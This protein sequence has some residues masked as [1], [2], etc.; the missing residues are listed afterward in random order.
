MTEKP[1]RRKSSIS[2]RLTVSI[3]GLGLFAVF[4]STA[5]RGYFHHRGNTQ[6]L[7]KHVA[8]VVDI[9]T[10]TLQEDAKQG[11]SDLEGT[12]RHLIQQPKIIYAQL[13]NLSTTSD[14]NITVEREHDKSSFMPVSTHQYFKIPT[15]VG[16]LTLHIYAEESSLDTGL[17]RVLIE[18]LF[19]EGGLVTCLVFF[20]I[21]TLK[22]RL[23]NHVSQITNF[24]RNLS[25]E[26]LG[27]SLEIIRHHDNAKNYD[28][29]DELVDAL[30]HM[31]GKFIDDLDQRRSMELALIREKEEKM[32][33]ERMIK[34]AEAA[35]L[36]KSKF[37]ATMSHEIRTPMNGVVG[38]VEMLRD[39]PLNDNQ[40]HYL[41]VIRRSSDSLMS[42]INDILDYSKIEAGRM[43]LEKV[44]FSLEELINDALQLFGGSNKKQNIQ[45]IS[46]ITPTT[47]IKL[48]GDPTR[49]RQVLVNLIGNAF[50]FTSEGYIFVEAHSLSTDYSEEPVIRFSIEDS[51]IGIKSEIKDSLFDAFRQADST[52]TRKY[53]GTGL[54]LAICKQLAEL[55]GGEIG[56]ES[57]ENKGSTF[58]FTAHLALPPEVDKRD[59]PSTSLSL[60]N[61]KLLA[62]HDSSILEKALR[63]HYVCW[64]LKCRTV[65]FA[66]DGL[67]LLK[68]SNKN[69]DRYDFILINR[70]LPDIDGIDLAIK[71]RKIRGY[72]NTP[73][74]MLT[75]SRPTSLT[76]E[77]L[78]A[79]TTI[80]PRPLSIMQI[81]NT[82]VAQ[83]S[84]ISLNT[85]EPT[86]P[87]KPQVKADLNVLVAEDNAVNRM[88]IEGLLNKFEIDPDFAENGQQAFDKITQPNAKYDLVFMDCEMPEMDG[89]EA[90][91][92]IRE[93]ESNQASKP[94]PIIALTAHVETE[95]RQRV[96]DCGMNYYLPKPISIDRLSEGLSA[97]GIEV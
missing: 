97:V 69:D 33:S 23:F 15:S 22:T 94:I 38:M 8:L 4:M 36:A 28:E 47:P 19:R 87:V 52:T 30:E 24:A 89:F 44:E 59:S 39:T 77:Q 46:S 67:D 25:L 48:V 72:E 16:V 12:L 53:G 20:M 82:L 51:G 81:K 84:G 79:V 27:D 13:L 90:T 18:A 54:G 65:Y 62:I 26:N 41:D 61:K 78:M 60:S 10:P 64:N 74:I 70:E 32:E 7:I 21:F 50:K 40:K 63:T 55:M 49:L 1:T 76:H 91:E 95:H 68:Q 37:I 92:K 73:I 80:I 45:L 42:I 17:A 29:L 34:E 11:K 5:L 6:H 3:L 2:R 43:N 31:R 86:E 88:V 75:D 85:L 93:W 71:I 56:V 58:W 9:I 96:F 66:E 35:N 57:T 14:L 83:A